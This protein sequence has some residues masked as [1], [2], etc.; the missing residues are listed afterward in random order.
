MKSIRLIGTDET[1]YSPVLYGDLIAV[2]LTTRDNYRIKGIV[3]SKKLSAEQRTKLFAE[4]C[5]TCYYSIAL[6]PPNL[7]ARTRI[8]KSRSIAI[9]QSIGQLFNTLPKDV[10]N[11]LNK[12]L[13]DGSWTASQLKVISK[14][15]GVPYDI[16]YGRIDGDDDIYEI[17]AASIVAKVYADALFCGWAN[18]WPEYNFDKDRGSVST[19]HRETLKTLGPTPI[20]RVEGYGENW[21]LKILAS[22]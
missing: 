6:S 11:S 2:S 13:I 3:D 1:G 10:K 4:I 7:I 16:I 9:A 14:I 5:K 20:H 15:S 19:K 17:S 12:V 22:E 21:W 18:L 8:F